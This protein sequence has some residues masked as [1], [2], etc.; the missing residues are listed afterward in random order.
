MLPQTC[1]PIEWR[2]YY[3]HKKIIFYDFATIGK[4]LPNS[5][6]DAATDSLH[7]KSNNS[8]SKFPFHDIN[9][10]FLLKATAIYW[11]ENSIGI[12]GSYAKLEKKGPPYI[13]CSLTY[14]MNSHKIRLLFQLSANMQ[15]CHHCT[16]KVIE[17]TFT[18]IALFL[19]VLPTCNKDLWS[20]CEKIITGFP[21]YK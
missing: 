20:C 9:D 11:F 13:L 3:Y 19:S 14:I 1:E 8:E 5:F 18:T 6:N 21:C 15:M 4:Q 7:K 17:V 2:W 12:D 16:T 10:R